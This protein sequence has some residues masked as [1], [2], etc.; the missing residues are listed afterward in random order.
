MLGQH[1]NDVFPADAVI[2]FRAQVRH[3]LVEGITC[4]HILGIIE[5]GGDAGDVGLGNLCN[6]A[7]PVFPVVTIANFLD[8]FCVNSAFDFPN[9]KF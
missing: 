7:S 8:D 5:D 6:I 4:L 2:Q 3:E 1:L 9:L